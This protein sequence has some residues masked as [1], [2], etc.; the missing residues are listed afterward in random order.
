MS[1][2]RARLAT[3]LI[4]VIVFGSGLMVG[5][6]WDSGT[7]VAAVEPT[8]TA[9]ARAEAPDSADAQPDSTT[10]RRRFYDR[11]DPTPDQKMAMDSI[12][13]THRERMRALND[14][15][16]EAYY[17]QYYG[18]IDES[19]ARIRERMTPEQAARYDSILAEFDKENR[20][21]EGRLPFRR[22]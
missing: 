1:T 3:A 4:L 10:T 7:E 20:N 11:V 16:R 6:A 12:V 13:E 19:R 21:Q 5:M 22:D 2:S 8:E 18:L 9:E 17:P 15:F 14:E